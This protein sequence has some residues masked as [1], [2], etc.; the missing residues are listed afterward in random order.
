MWNLIP[1]VSLLNTRKQQK[2]SVIAFR[3]VIS[4]WMLVCIILFSFKCIL[5]MILTFYWSLVHL[6]GPMIRF[7]RAKFQFYMFRN[8]LGRRTWR[9][10]PSTSLSV[11]CPGCNVANW[12]VLQH[13]D[14]SDGQ[15]KDFLMASNKY[16]RQWFDQELGKALLSSGVRRLKETQLPLTPATKLAQTAHMWRENREDFLAIAGMINVDNLFILHCATKSAPF[17]SL[18][19]GMRGPI[20]RQNSI[21]RPETA[22]LVYATSTEDFYLLFEALAAATDTVF[23]R[24]RAVD[25]HYWR[26]LECLQGQQKALQHFWMGTC[27]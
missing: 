27:S 16:T 12:E 10:N 4:I 15:P 7:S 22:V 5:N 3:S 9:G 21:K 19:R 2:C 8:F 23:I 25:G 17:G 1:N 18:P 13:L 11:K 24:A 6:L 20:Y 26:F 14:L